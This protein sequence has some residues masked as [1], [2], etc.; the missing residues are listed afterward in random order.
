MSRIGGPWHSIPGGA[1][2][3]EVHRVVGEWTRV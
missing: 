3:G 2:L 1:H